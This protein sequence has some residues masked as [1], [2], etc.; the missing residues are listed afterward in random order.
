MV[1]HQNCCLCKTRLRRKA[2]RNIAPDTPLHRKLKLSYEDL[3]NEE[4]CLC[5]KCRRKIYRN[6]WQAQERE[7]VECFLVSLQSSHKVCFI[8]QSKKHVLV[9]LGSAARTDI[10]LR[11]KILIP[12]G[13]RCCQRHLQ[14]GVIKNSV[15]LENVTCTPVPTSQEVYVFKVILYSF[16]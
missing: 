8:C 10:Y 5:D 16:I 13:T 4:L 12:S 11:H 6:D 1:K 3:P 9:T 14:A 2:W 15:S 7:N